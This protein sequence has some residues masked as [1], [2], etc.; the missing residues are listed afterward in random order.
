M[1][2]GVLSNS[3]NHI[4]LCAFCLYF[5]SLSFLRFFLSVRSL[6]FCVNIRNWLIKTP[7]FK[8]KI[9]GCINWVVVHFHLRKPSIT[10][11]RRKKKTVFKPRLFLWLMRLKIIHIMVFCRLKIFAYGIFFCFSE[12]ILSVLDS[13]RAAEVGCRQSPFANKILS[14]LSLTMDKMTTLPNLPFFH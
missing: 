9:L 1:S 13:E 6:L 7:P 10:V 14:L 12:F 4:G 8:H 5:F 11:A 3:Y 2:Q